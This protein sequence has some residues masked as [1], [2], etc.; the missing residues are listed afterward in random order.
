[1]INVRYWEN[2][3]S[4]TGEGVFARAAGNRLPLNRG[5]GVSA[6]YER[7]KLTGNRIRAPKP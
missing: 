6:I 1:M 3:P 4:L 7:F 5:V 2:T